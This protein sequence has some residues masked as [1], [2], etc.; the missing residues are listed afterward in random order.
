[1]SA[2]MTGIK[3]RRVQCSTCNEFFGADV[4]HRHEQTCQKHLDEK[5][6]RIALM[7]S[8]EYK[9]KR[10]EILRTAMNRP[11]VVAKILKT[12]RNPEYRLNHSIIMKAVP[13]FECP[14]C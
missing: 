7:N 6:N 12:R 4:I 13:K 8:P 1:M 2:A 3:Q 9:A 10:S 11:E 5:A 14:H